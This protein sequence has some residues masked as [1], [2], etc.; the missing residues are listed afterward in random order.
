MSFPGELLAQPVETGLCGHKN[1]LLAFGRFDLLPQKDVYAEG[2]KIGVRGRLLRG[3]LQRRAQQ[4]AR[5]IGQPFDLRQNR[6]FAGL[7]PHPG[8]AWAE[9]QQYEGQPAA[10]Q[11]AGPECQCFVYCAFH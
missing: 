10:Q 8:S 6:R 3:Q 11:Q 4:A 9:R 2:G 1:G 7:R 5:Q